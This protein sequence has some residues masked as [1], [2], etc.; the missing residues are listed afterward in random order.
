MAG[1]VCVPVESSYPLE[2]G[3]QEN[4]KLNYKYKL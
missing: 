3:G 1:A 2:R 4:Y